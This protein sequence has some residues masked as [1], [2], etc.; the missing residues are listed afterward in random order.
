MRFLCVCPLTLHLHPTTSEGCGGACTSSL[1]CQVSQK[2]DSH[3]FTGPEEAVS[4]F[5]Q[6]KVAVCMF[7]VRACRSWSSSLVAHQRAVKHRWLVPDAISVPFL[8]RKVCRSHF[9]QFHRTPQKWK[10]YKKSGWICYPFLNI[11]QAAAAAKTSVERFLHESKGTVLHS[12]WTLQLIHNGPYSKKQKLVLSSH[13]LSQHEQQ[14]CQP[15]DSP[16]HTLTGTFLWTGKGIALWQ[17]PEEHNSYFKTYYI[18]ST[19][20]CLQTF[21]LK[22][23]QT[24]P[25]QSF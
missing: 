19:C 14:V 9:F 1:S 25:N 22:F 16:I 18:W 10:T 2:G 8:L 5:P 20:L 6:R 3:L 23:W 24:A 7:Y 17:K 11:R 15:H 12:L 21:S 4:S 13:L